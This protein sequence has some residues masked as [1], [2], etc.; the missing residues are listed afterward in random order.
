MQHQRE[1]NKLLGLISDETINILQES[2][3]IIA[4]GA[5][6]SIFCNNEV[7][8]IDAYFKSE[9]DFML[10]V[11][12]V[13]SGGHYLIC[14]NY[15]DRSI[16]F[17]DKDTGQDVQAIV[18]KFFPDADAIFADYDYTIN[19]AAYDC[20]TEE[21]HLHEDFLKH[22]SQR[23]LQFNTGTAYPLISAL[24]VNKYVDRGY[25]ISKPQYLRIMMTIAQLKLESWADVRD[26]VAGMYGLDLTQVFPDETEFSIDKAIEILDGIEPD[27]KIWS[28]RTDIDEDEIISK[29]FDGRYKDGRESC[30]GLYFKNVM[31]KPDGTICSH[32][33]PEFE[34]VIGGTVDGGSN[35][36]YFAEGYGVLSACYHDSDNN[37]ILQI[38][39][40]KPTARWESSFKGE[41]R[42]VAKYTRGEFYRKFKK[43]NS[44][45]N[46]FTLA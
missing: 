36:I 25:T 19:M 37:V 12:L 30:E 13:F 21:L 34:Y 46:T 15:T 10:F 5:L 17:K 38:E 35:G 28:P 20:A 24:R 7:N 16:L 27:A 29:Y 6:T 39:G 22:N 33:K 18:Y 1:I 14:N 23:Y 3:A 26:H 44:N 11:N 41:V 43:T 32:F 2:N 4:G 45:S 8:D 9:G 31:L 42:V 40:E